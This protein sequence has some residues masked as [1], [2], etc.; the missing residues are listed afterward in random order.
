MKES[1]LFLFLAILVVGILLFAAITF[2]KNTPKRLNVDK[3]RVKWL[4][5]EQQLKKDN[6]SGCHMA[7]MNA[8]KLLGHALKELGV[9]GQTMGERMKAS[10]QK[11]SNNNAV[12]SAHKLRNRL[13]HE[14]DASVSYDQARRALA[15]FKRALKDLGAI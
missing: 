12:W 2:S 1:I 4:T 3:Y 6:I 7:V 9:K 5:I 8:D 14:P 13:A 11:F 10:R 15:A